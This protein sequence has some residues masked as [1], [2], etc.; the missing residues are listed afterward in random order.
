M[1]LYL[2]LKGGMYCFKDYL[3]TLWMSSHLRCH[4][5]EKHPEEQQ[6]GSRFWILSVPPGSAELAKENNLEMVIFFCVS[7]ITT[8][9]QIKLEVEQPYKDPLNNLCLPSL[10]TESYLT[11]LVFPSWLRE[12]PLAVSRQ[13]PGEIQ[14]LV[15]ALSCTG[16]YFEM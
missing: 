9:Q 3:Q 1:F 16:A 6:K 10:L 13:E 4:F 11:L 12:I 15:V 8:S 14:E 7:Y 5:K 2:S